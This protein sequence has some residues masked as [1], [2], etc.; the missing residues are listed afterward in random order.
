[1]PLDLSKLARNA[2][3]STVREQNNLWLS[4]ISTIRPTSCWL[5]NGKSNSVWNPSAHAPGV[6]D[7]S[8]QSNIDHQEV[9]S[10]YL[11]YEDVKCNARFCRKFKNIF[12]ETISFLYSLGYIHVLC[13]IRWGPTY[14]FPSLNLNNRAISE[15][16]IAYL[17]YLALYPC[18]YHC[19][20]YR[21]EDTLGINI[22][23]KKGGYRNRFLLF[24]SFKKPLPTWAKRWLQLVVFLSSP[25]IRG[26]LRLSRV[27][28]TSRVFTSGYVN[29]E[30]ILHF[31]NVN[32]WIASYNLEANL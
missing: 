21:T 14:S 19:N 10:S 17:L 24:F 30:T 18:K 15:K 16:F 28:P 11:F 4:V 31:F 32:R 25:S 22:Y 29:T 3:I 26:F 6:T 1:M 2:S 5:S 27:L 7:R 20:I 8:R 13:V 9:T 12:G 23:V